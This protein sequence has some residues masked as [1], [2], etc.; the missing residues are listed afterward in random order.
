ME[1]LE[2]RAATRKTAAGLEFL[3]I[4]KAVAAGGKVKPEA[5]EAVLTAAGQTPADFRG[6]VAIQTERL[7]LRGL[8]AT[9]PALTAEKAK[10]ETALQLANEKFQRALADL[11]AVDGPL[12]NQ[13]ADNG[14]QQAAALTAQEKLVDTAPLEMIDQLE[15]L[16]SERTTLG[17]EQLKLRQRVQNLPGIIKTDIQAIGGPCLDGSFRELHWIEE[18]TKHTA[19]LAAA[20]ARVVEIEPMIADLDRQIAAAE[21]A[22]RTA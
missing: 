14:I 5:V 13:L 18:R 12:R 20:A 9:L 16:R 3:R 10:I 17:D 7:R 4:A 2:V 6:A 19:E 15:T 1:E 22:A 21:S 11:G 8:V